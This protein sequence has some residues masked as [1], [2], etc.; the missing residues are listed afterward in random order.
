M[1]MPGLSHLVWAIMAH[2]YILLYCTC[3]DV[4]PFYV[5]AL[6]M[7]TAL[8]LAW[9]ISQLHTQHRQKSSPKTLLPLR[10]LV[11]S[12]SEYRCRL[13]FWSWCPN[14]KAQTRCL[15]KIQWCRAITAQ[16][17]ATRPNLFHGEARR[18]WPKRPSMYAL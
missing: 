8:E 15:R 4:Y 7:I 16:V 11:S 13:C 3:I 18:F 10:T 17:P 14:R 5:T 6:D 12:R 2:I 1:L 9:L